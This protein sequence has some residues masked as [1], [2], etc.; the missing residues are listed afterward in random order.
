MKLAWV[1]APPWANTGYAKVTRNFISRIKYPE[2]VC[3]TTGGLHAGPFVEWNGIKVYPG[4]QAEVGKGNIT[5]Y[6]LERVL[7]DEKC[8][9]WVFHSDAWAYRKLIRDV[10][11]K[12]NAILYSPIDGG[13]VS[14][15][16]VQALQIAQERVAMCKYAEKE[17]QKAGMSTTYIPHGVDTKV[18]KP[19]NK[20]ECREKMGLPKD[21][22]IVGFIG[23]NI[24]KRKGQAEMMMGFKKAI[25]AGKQFMAVL[26]TD[27]DGQNV[28]GYNFWQ[29]A[30]YVGVPRGVM[31]FP[32][33]MYTF[34]EE[35]MAI[36]Y[37]SFDVLVNLS[38][39]EGFGI[40]ILEAE[41]CGTP[42]IATDFTSMTELVGGHGMLVPVRILD[43]YTLK[44][45][46][47]AIA[48]YDAFGDALI[49]CIDNHDLV[50]SMGKRAHQFAQK[51]DWDKIAPKWDTMF[52]K[53][54][55]QGFFPPYLVKEFA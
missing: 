49:K 41:A 24:S 6:A 8:T 27:Q 43:I 13:H 52:R 31:L 40:P 26:G 2:I 7:R 9:H 10:G 11:V 32:A 45:Q 55:K 35:E 16:E 23:T 54:D 33:N 12:Y 17:I 15:E 4:M 20:D 22:F 38:R 47:H 3:V 46:Y 1:S 51:Y 5:L 25:D 34:T 39:G 50:K 48:D 28:G 18:F 36:M 19:L 21:K 53:L 29:L 42:V 14:P 37:N 44:T 30:D